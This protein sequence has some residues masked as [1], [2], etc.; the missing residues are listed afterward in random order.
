MSSWLHGLVL[1]LPVLTASGQ[2]LG[3]PD[4]VQPKAK[5]HVM[6]VAEQQ[7]V[8]AGKHA[9]IALRF[10]VDE[11]YHVN[12]HLPKSELLIPTQVEFGAASGVKLA[13]AEYPAGKLY[14]FSF[15]PA[16]KLDVYTDDFVV[17]L[18][19]VASAGSHELKGELKY[20]ACDKAA[21]YPVRT[22]PVQVL[23]SAK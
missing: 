3:S 17:R 14:S 12:S 19:V 18:P 10:H 2:E 20:Q 1:M 9:S 22:L 23:F 6:Y 5:Q 4:G 7:T 21:C 16:T 8:A 13:N 15:D 11:G